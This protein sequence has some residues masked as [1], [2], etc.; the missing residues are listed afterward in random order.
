M[1]AS[2]V[3]DLVLVSLGEQCLRE[4]HNSED[5]CM[6]SKLDGIAIRWVGFNSE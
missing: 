6:K 4:A 2:V 5:T 1:T 3:Q